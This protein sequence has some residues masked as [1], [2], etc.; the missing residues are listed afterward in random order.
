MGVGDIHLVIGRAEHETG[1][2]V[3]REG[4][5]VAEN[6]KAQVLGTGDAHATHASGGRHH[7]EVKI[8]TV[9]GCSGAVAGKPAK[10]T[11]AAVLWIVL[12]G[13]PIQFFQT[14]SLASDTCFPFAI[15]TPVTCCGR[16]RMSS[17]G[18]VRSTVW[19][20]VSSCSSEAGLLISVSKVMRL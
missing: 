18:Q 13:P 8:G 5:G 7:R 2:L 6:R 12:I 3:L 17:T 1:T 15:A 4:R 16:L 14:A 19:T 9:I 20:S 11:T 10:A